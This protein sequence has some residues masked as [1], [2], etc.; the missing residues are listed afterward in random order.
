MNSSRVFLLAPGAA[1]LALLVAV[2]GDSMDSKLFIVSALIIALAIIS[3]SG[4]VATFVRHESTSKKL[5]AGI[6]M[7]LGLYL[8]LIS[9]YRLMLSGV[10][11]LG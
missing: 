11:F 2:I 8:G 10:G 4:A 6:A 9:V 1:F 5:I 3:T 7:A